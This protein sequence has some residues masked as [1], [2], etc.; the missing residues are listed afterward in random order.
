MEKILTT[1]I[2]SVF[3]TFLF[4]SCSKKLPENEKEEID[5]IKLTPLSFEQVQIDTC[6]LFYGAQDY[7][8]AQTIAYQ[9]GDSAF[10]LIPSSEGFSFFNLKTGK[11]SRFV[12]LKTDGEGSLRGEVTCFKALSKDTLVVLTDQ[13]IL[14]ILGGDGEILAEK[15]L[16]LNASEV[17]TY[18]VNGDHAA[19]K[20]I[21]TSGGE[22]IV[23]LM[24]WKNRDSKAFYEGNIFLKASF[25]DGAQPLTFGKYPSLFL[26]SGIF[27]SMEEYFMS[28]GIGEKG[29]TVSFMATDRLM[30]YDLRLPESPQFFSVP[31][32]FENEKPKPFLAEG[33]RFNS[34][35]EEEINYLIES[36]FF[37]W[38][39]YA[40]KAGLYYRLVKHRQDKKGS[41]D[42]LKVPQEAPL[43][44]QVFSLI[45]KK[46]Y[47]FELPHKQFV[48]LAFT[49]KDSLY[50]MLQEQE[51]EGELL[52]LKMKTNL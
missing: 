13:H 25:D 34:R 11:P 33:E 2:L 38:T 30:H 29:M 50:L 45:E 24:N 21:L 8:F 16:S 5:K 22:I 36:P 31:S 32:V 19:S 40:D 37:F 41:D 10:A 52:F 17:Q 43:S 9:K 47:E 14:Y 35:H 18:G 39:L 15:G 44:I 7:Q 51:N 6:K 48:W 46:G 26:E 20:M 23:G 3:V 4:N 28:Q 1:L 42:R 27:Y 49:D 12:P